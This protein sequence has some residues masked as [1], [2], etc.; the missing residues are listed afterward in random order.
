MFSGDNPEYCNGIY[1][2]DSKVY[3]LLDTMSSSYTYTGYNDAVIM[4]FEQSSGRLKAGKFFSLGTSM[5]LGSGLGKINQGALV[6]AGASKKANGFNFGYNAAFI[7]KVD[8]LTSKY[9]C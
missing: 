1:Q 7:Q 2:E 6:F 5:T 8:F 9:S 4:Q 3:V